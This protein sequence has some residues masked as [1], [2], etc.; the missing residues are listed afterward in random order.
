MV[1]E[2]RFQEVL[3]NVNFVFCSIVVVRRHD[4]EHASCLPLRVCGST[5]CSVAMRQE[6]PA[7]AAISWPG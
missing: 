5:L 4:A 3:R 2:E 1:L 7:A 6:F